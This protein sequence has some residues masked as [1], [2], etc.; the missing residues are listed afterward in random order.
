VRFARVAASL[1][2]ALFAGTAAAAD[3]PKPIAIGV[4]PSVP[5]GST[6]IALEKGYFRDAGLDV[7]IGTLDS[8]SQTIPFLASNRMQLVQGG[9]SVGYF[10]ALAQGLPITMILDVGSSPLYHDLLV[11]PD[12]AG[13]IKTMA[14]LKGRPVALVSAGAIT[15]YELGK[16][17]E[18]GGLTIKDVEIKYIPFTQMGA[19]FANKAI[20][21]GLEVPP[22]GD[23][24]V[25]QGIA[26][27]W[28]DP[29][30]LVQPSPMSIVAYMINTDWAKQ[31]PDVAHRLFVALVRAGREYCQAYHHGPNRPEVE[32]I[33]I[34]NKVMTD[35]D[36]L[37]K[38]PWQSRDPNGRFNMASL[39]DVQD[40]FF[41]EHMIDQKVPAERIANNDYADAAAKELGP[42]ELVNKSDPLQ[43]CR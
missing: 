39:V 23:L 28:V 11:R 37:E 1:G 33:M 10:N 21:V 35:R 24:I 8:A 34:K 26:A 43:G 18:T 41:R 13:T 32:D 20:D 40:W 30:K 25:D 36:L 9:V 3:A 12:L 22:F 17:L 42:F 38:T 6:Y 19:A 7:T 5:A 15:T 2:F 27:K 31:N 14:D 4:V 29:D 16:S